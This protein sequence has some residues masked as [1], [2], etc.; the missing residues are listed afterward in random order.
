M[1]TDATE[2]D[3]LEYLTNTFESSGFTCTKLNTKAEYACFRIAAPV[4][5][6]DKI[7]DPGLWPAGVVV[8]P[9]YFR[10]DRSPFLERQNATRNIEQ[11]MN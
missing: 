6:K 5:L 8:R 10:S 1:N 7:D 4:E 3:L 11:S 2:G 9:F